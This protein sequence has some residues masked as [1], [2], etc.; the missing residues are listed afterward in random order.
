MHYLFMYTVS[1][2]YYYYYYYH[3]HHHQSISQPYAGYLQLDAPKKCFQGTQCC[4]YSV[5]TVYGTCIVIS[6]D[7]RFALLHKYLLKY[8]CSAQY[9]AVFCSSLMSCFPG[10]L[11]RLLLLLLLL[12]LLLLLLLNCNSHNR[13]KCRHL[14]TDKA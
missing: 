11:L 9:M 1:N 10:M 4:S 5:A 3:Y 2:Y 12:F 14:S 6:H 13:N 7:K 8:V